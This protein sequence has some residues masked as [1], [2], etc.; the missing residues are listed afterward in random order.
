[1]KSIYLISLLCIPALIFSQSSGDHNEQ[2]ESLFIGHIT[3]E[4]DLSPEESRAFW[5][6]YNAYRKAS[7]K[8]RK[9]SHSFR[10]NAIEVTSDA[11]ALQIL[12]D[13]LTADQ[14]RLDL[15]RQLYKELSDIISSQRILKLKSAEHQFRRQMFDRIKD[16]SGI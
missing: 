1:M 2:I 11:Q 9:I 15:K 12:N 16:K 8:A 13:H 3:S 4:L 10:H 6:V 14:K 7:D 5:P